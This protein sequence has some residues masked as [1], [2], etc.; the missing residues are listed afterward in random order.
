MRHRFLACAAALVMTI[1]V[2]STFIAQADTDLDAVKDAIGTGQRIIDTMQRI[3]QILSEAKAPVRQ[4]VS[5]V[6]MGMHSLSP[7]D[8][9][10]NA[11]AV[12]NL[13]E[14]AESEHFDP[15]IDVVVDF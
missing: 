10:L 14:G 13:L 9:R 7:E 5:F 3:G 4:A 1:L 11:Q 6:V 15:A 2:I 8:S 12:V